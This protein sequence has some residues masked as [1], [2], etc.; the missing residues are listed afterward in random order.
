MGTVAGG[1]DASNAQ[2]LSQNPE[3]Q[4]AIELQYQ[5]MARQSGGMAQMPIRVGGSPRANAMWQQVAK[6]SDKAVSL[7]G[8]E[9]MLS[10]PEN[11]YSGGS[12][13]T[14]RIG[15]SASGV[16]YDTSGNLMINKTSIIP[17]APTPTTTSPP[18]AAAPWTPPTPA[19][20]TLT[21]PTPPVRNP[22]PPPPGGSTVDDI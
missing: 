10:V 22:P 19:S 18:A 3:L 7:F 11:V 16:E 13:T 1:G 8:S 14:V 17:P 21:P 15:T 4:K 20:T 9:Q 2:D 6:L 5:Q 12:G